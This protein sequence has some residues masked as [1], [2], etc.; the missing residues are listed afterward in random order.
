MVVVGEAWIFLQISRISP[1]HLKSGPRSNPYVTTRASIHK[2]TPLRNVAWSRW[3]P[4][5]TATPSVVKPWWSLVH[6][7]VSPEISACHH[8]F[9]YLFLV[10]CR[11]VWK[12]RYGKKWWRV[13]IFFFR[14]VGF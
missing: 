13:K 2:R 6:R 7:F 12:V 4:R 10:A 5:R 9:H 11:L 1:N 8:P 3:H 14:K